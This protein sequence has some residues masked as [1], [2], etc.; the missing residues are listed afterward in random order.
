MVSHFGLWFDK[1]VVPMDQNSSGGKEE[2]EAGDGSSSQGKIKK[3]SISKIITTDLIMS[4]HEIFKA[5]KC[6]H[7]S[8]AR[9]IELYLRESRANRMRKET[10][11][12]LPP[13]EVD[14]ALIYFSS[15]AAPSA[16]AL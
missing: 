5:Y 10:A 14:N 11:R 7:S 2:V 13:Y 6:A 4:F 15:I 16:S 8:Y 12:W 9:N 1:N 3:R